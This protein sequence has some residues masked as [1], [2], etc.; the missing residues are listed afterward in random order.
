MVYCEK[1]SLRVMKAFKPGDALSDGEVEREAGQRTLTTTILLSIMVKCQF[2]R[3]LPQ[4][5]RRHEGTRT[6]L[7]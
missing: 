6:R 7:R 5:T 3:S 2:Y 1:S 4:V